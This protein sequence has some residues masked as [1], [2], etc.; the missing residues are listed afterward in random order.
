[1]VFLSRQPQELV[2]RDVEDMPTTPRASQEAPPLIR[3]REPPRA[4]LGCIQVP[5]D[6]VLD[7]E[8]AAL[9]AKIPGVEI[10][11]TKM[12]FGTDAIKASTFRSALP[13]LGRA[14]GALLPRDR[15]TVLGVA[16]TSFS[17]TVGPTAID[18]ELR[19]ATCNAAKTTDMSRAQAAAIAALGARRV[20]LLTPYIE[21]LS[22]ANEAMLRS[23]AGVEVVRR[24]TMGLE[25]DA[26]TTAV[27]QGTIKR[28]AEF[29]DCAAA[30]V[31]VV[32]CSAFRA[33]SPGFVDEL[34]AA[35]GKPVV[36]STQAFLWRMLRLAGVR[37]QVDG[38]GKLFR[39]H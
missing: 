24:V 26:L 20:A 27:S 30:E 16:C 10:R 39:E 29:A 34:E 32:G 7:H 31:V 35:L 14:A 1:M 21:P 3:W 5:T 38:Y 22:R 37:D 25:R 33:C 17:F 18:R 8:G 4:V 15:C 36:T 11:L 9:L 12:E 19:A 6:Y 2:L 28:W 13:N 23:S